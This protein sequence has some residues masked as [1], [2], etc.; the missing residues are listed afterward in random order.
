MQ[1][2][3]NYGGTVAIG[4]DIMKSWTD[5]EEDLAPFTVLNNGFDG[6]RTWELLA[7]ADKLV[8]NFRPKSVIIYGG[9]NDMD[10]REQA[11]PI[12]KRI[13]AFMKYL[14]DALPGV[15]IIYISISKAPQK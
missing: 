14:D 11:T 1:S 3:S 15:Q 12:A 10:F 4:N 7:Y 13:G 6:S 2:P 5:I 9:S 8:T